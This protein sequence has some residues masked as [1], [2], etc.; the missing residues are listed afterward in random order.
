MTDQSN[1]QVIEICF[2]NGGA[3]LVKN[4]LE[5]GEIQENLAVSNQEMI[6]MTSK[7]FVQCANCDNIFSQTDFQSHVCDFGED[8]KLISE[9]SDIITVAEPLSFLT[10]HPCFAQLEENCIKIRRF[11]KEELKITLKNT[12]PY[13]M[14]KV[15]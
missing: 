14:P 6:L 13:P 4:G 11:I 8:K 1:Q 5:M 9:D 3:E 2:N 7:Y 10:N 12:L 15:S